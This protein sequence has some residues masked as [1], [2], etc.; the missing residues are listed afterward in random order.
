MSAGKIKLPILVEDLGMHFPNETSK[1]K[2]RY[3]MFTCMCGN[4]FKAQIGD[5]KKG[6]TKSCGCLAKTSVVEANTTHGLS[7]HP[8][9]K[10]WQNMI[11]RTSNKKNMNY[12]YYGGR[13]IGVSAEWLDV[14]NFINDMYSTYS[15][16]LTLD[17]IDVNG[18][19]CKENCRWV[20]KAVQSQNT[21]CLPVTNK[22]GYRG[23]LLKKGLNKW[24]AQINMYG[25]HIHIG[26]Y[27]NKE[28][29]ARAYN[30]YV[31]NSGASHTLNTIEEAS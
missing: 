29:A 22:S 14:S 13:G 2:A 7:K 20:T 19:Y 10:V 5:V 16:G 21:R 12:K 17:R 11:N 3:G 6:C 25:K 4:S 18:N 15:K 28:D 9:Y 1:R 27:S 23:V 31:I 8:I 24:V 26:C 30:D